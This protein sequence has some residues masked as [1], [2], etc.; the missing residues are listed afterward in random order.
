MKLGLAVAPEKA[1]PLAFVVYRGKIENILDKVSRLGYNGVELALA[2][3]E[4]INVKELKE[5]LNHFKLEIPVIST[6][7][8]FAE[9]NVSL[10]HQKTE[11]RERAIELMRSLIDIASEFN[12]KVNMGRIRGII[13]G[14]ER[15]AVEERFIETTS[16][17][18]SYAREKRVELILEPIN[19][20]E[21][22]FINT[23]QEGLDLIEKFNGFGFNNIGL[24]PDLFHM[25]I[26]ERNIIE[27]LKMA[28]DKISYIHFADSNR[29]APGQGHL[30]FRSIINTLKDIGYDGYVTLEILPK[31][32]PDTSASIG[33][34]FL[35]SIVEA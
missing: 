24:M 11:I 23:L 5:L 31:P 17:L 18:L 22:D 7:R 8:V 32:D 28:K 19:R 20:Y 3:S 21:T 34:K 10:S 6:G 30:D 13:D 16:I 2:S 1:T 4:E 12:A 33:I 26:E 29:Y 25:N 14:E 9:Y 35:K 15:E 27:S